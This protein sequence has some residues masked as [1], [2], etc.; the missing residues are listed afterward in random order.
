MEI[1][2]KGKIEGFHIVKDENFIEHESGARMHYVLL[3][4]QGKYPRELGSARCDFVS[5]DENNLLV[6]SR[7]G[8]FH[9]QNLI[10]I[11]IE[12][13]KGLELWSNGYLPNYYVGIVLKKEV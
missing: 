13:I 10:E 7:D 6:E 8:Q 1:T 3:L 5:W 4:Y 2:T 12:E 9:T 11:P